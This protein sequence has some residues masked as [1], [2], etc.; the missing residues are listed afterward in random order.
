MGLSTANGGPRF[1]ERYDDGRALRTRRLRRALADLSEY[2]DDVRA[3]R[4]AAE[5]VVAAEDMRH[6]AAYGQP[7]NMP[8]LLQL[9]ARAERAVAKLKGGK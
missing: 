8:L 3:V 7:V 1:I 4:R 9:D 2:S 6:R 5:L